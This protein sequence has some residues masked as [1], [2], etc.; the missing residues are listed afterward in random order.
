MKNVAGELCGCFAP[1]TFLLADT[2]YTASLCFA[3]I[4]FGN[5]FYP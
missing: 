3:H 5:L 4:V 2:G 1:L